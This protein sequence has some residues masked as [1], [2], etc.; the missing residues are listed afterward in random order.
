MYPNFQGGCMSIPTYLTQFH[1]SI[2]ILNF[3]NLAT[4]FPFHL[5]LSRNI[6]TSAL[7]CAKRAYLA[8]RTI[9]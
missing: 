4:C 6:L 5:P 2:Y 8:P 1:G 3:L 7:L 9:F